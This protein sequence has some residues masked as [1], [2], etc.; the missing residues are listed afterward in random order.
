MDLIWQGLR[1]AFELLASGDPEIWR[2]TMRTIQVSGTATFIAVA[3]GV[4]PGIFLALGRFPGRRL[5]ISVV[6]TAMGLPPVV[7]GLWVAVLLSR[8]G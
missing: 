4:P 5:V 7:L 3:L 2:I 6:N 1:K 8:Y